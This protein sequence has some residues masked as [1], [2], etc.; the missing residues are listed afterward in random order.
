MFNRMFTAVD[1]LWFTGPVYC[2]L[3]TAVLVCGGRI[4]VRLVLPGE[5]LSQDHMKPA[6]WFIF[7]S[8]LSSLRPGWSASLF[9]RNTVLSI[10]LSLGLGDPL[11]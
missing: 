9:V 3:R 1:S 7:T 6:W 8:E 4:A 5:K 10:A 2:L 11:L